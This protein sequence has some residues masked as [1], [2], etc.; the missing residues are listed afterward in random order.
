[1]TLS[2][3]SPNTPGPAGAGLLPPEAG[4]GSGICKPDLCN[5]MYNICKYSHIL[6]YMYNVEQY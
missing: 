5:F 3:P 4:L 6:T 1:M 2:I